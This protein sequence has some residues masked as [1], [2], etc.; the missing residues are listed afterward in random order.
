MRGVNYKLI[1]CHAMTALINCAL[2]F[3]KTTKIATVSC[4]CNRHLIYFDLRHHG[5]SAILVLS[6]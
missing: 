3:P 4:N 2:F 1:A 6:I 5:V